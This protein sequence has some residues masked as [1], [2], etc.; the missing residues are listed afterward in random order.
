MPGWNS[1]LRKPHWDHYPKEK[2]LFRGHQ[3]PLPHTVNLSPKQ[4]THSFLLVLDYPFPFLGHNLVHRL[5]NTITILPKDTEISISCIPVPFNHSPVWRI[6][7][8][9]FITVTNWNQVT[10]TICCSK[11]RLPRYRFL[12]VNHFVI[13]FKLTFC[14]RFYVSLVISNKLANLEVWKVTQQ[15]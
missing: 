2:V 15:P 10:C 3:G 9:F 8:R 14:Y 1:P 11:L 6:V 13:R 7:P 12:L 5:G 4:V